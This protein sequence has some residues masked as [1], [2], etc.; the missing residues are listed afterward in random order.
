[1][2]QREWGE[3]GGGLNRVRKIEIVE[4]GSRKERDGGREKERERSAVGERDY[5]RD[6]EMYCIRVTDY[7][8]H[9]RCW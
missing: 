7:G 5:S 3:V 9:S 1:M 6:G 2:T 8:V 4:R